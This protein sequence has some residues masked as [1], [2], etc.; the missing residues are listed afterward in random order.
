MIIVMKIAGDKS[1]QYETITAAALISPGM[2][3]L[4]TD[5][6]PYANPQAGSIKCSK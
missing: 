3:A 6:H 5:I 2:I 1:V 4:Q